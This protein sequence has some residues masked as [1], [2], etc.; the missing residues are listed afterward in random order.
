MMPYSRN[1]VMWQMSFP[2]PE[3]EA[4][5]LSTKGPEVLKQEAILRTP[6]HTPIPQVL[7]A[8]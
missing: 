3:D 1:E 4:I 2:M 5:I 6:W 8:T 7:S